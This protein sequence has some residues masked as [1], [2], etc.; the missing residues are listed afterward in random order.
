MLQLVLATR[1]G[2]KTHRTQREVPIFAL[3][4]AKS[5]PKMKEAKP[6][7][8]YSNGT[9]LADGSPAG[10]STLVGLTGQGVTMAALA[11]PLS[12]IGLGREVVDRTDLTAKY[13]FALRCAPVE[14]MRPVINGQMQPLSPE[15]LALPSIF[16]AL[17]EQMGLKLEPTKGLV[18]TLTV[19]H[20]DRPSEN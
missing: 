13:D 9:R 19:D 6:G 14:A 7:D 5:G 8:P 10:A 17:Q 18:E 4:V 2:L 20:I 16:T 12:R 11:V 1:F 15:D 3:V